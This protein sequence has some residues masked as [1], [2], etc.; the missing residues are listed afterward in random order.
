[1]ANYIDVP[2][3]MIESIVEVNRS[4]KDFIAVCY[5]D[6]YSRGDYNKNEARA[7]IIGVYRL[8]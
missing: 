4:R 8:P 1:M 3:D 5:Y 2:Q 6:Y 7:G